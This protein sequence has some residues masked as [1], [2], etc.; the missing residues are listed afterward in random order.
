MKKILVFVF[1]CLFCIYNAECAVR[2][3]N[4]I[5]RG[6]SAQNTVS[7]K[8]VKTRNVRA[9]TTPNVTNR[10]SRKSTVETTP[11][12]QSVST[13]TAVN[14]RAS[15]ATRNST[16]K[17]Q[18]VVARATTADQVQSV[19]SETKTGLEY[20]QC[21]TAFFTCMDQFCQLKNDNYRRCSCSNRI[22]NFQEVSDGYKQASEKLTEFSE[23]LDVVGMSKEQATAMKTASEGEDALT[24]DK[25]A[26]KQLLQA[27]MNAIKGDDAKVG[28]KYQNLNSISL[29]EDF[30]NAFENADSGQ[31]IASYN[32]ATLY[33]AVFPR[34]KSVVKEDCNNASLQR[35]INAY[36]MAIEQDCNTVEAALKTQ[37]KKLK[38]STYQSSAM[39]DLARI[40]NRH[41][42]NEDDIATCMTNVEAAIQSE[43]V[44]GEKYHKC[45]D[46][47]QYIDITT[48][49][50]I[51]GVVDFYKLGSLLTFKTAETIENQHLSLISSNRQFVQFF[52]NKTKKF[53]KDALDKCSEQADTVW[54]QYLDRALVDI[55][56]MQQS[57]VKEI[58]QSCLDLVT[59]CYANQS[60]SIATAMANLTGDSSILI[61]PSVINLTTQMC[62][63]YI[64]SCNNMF[65]EETITAYINN[66]DSADAE[67]ACR[68]VVQQCFEKF[69]GTRY[70]N[71]Y[72]TQSGLFVP[73]SA[74]D[75]FTLYSYSTPQEFGNSN[76]HVV[77]DFIDKTNSNEFVIVS[78][79]AQ[80]LYNTEGCNSPEILER[81]FGGFNKYTYAGKTFYSYA[82]DMSYTVADATT[83]QEITYYFPETQP[84]SDDRITRSKGVATETYANIIDI[85]STQ[86]AGLKGKF[87]EYQNVS[88][89]GYNTTNSCKINTVDSTSAFFIGTDL[90]STLDYWYHFIPNE[91]MCP[92]HYAAKID[93][94]SWGI[95]SCWENGRY[96]SKNGTAQVCI[97]VL[98]IAQTSEDGTSDP[99]C[100][101]E[102]LG[103]T[104][105]SDL[106]SATH[107]WCQQSVSSS[108]G[109]ICPT[110][111]TAV[112]NSSVSCKF[113]TSWESSQTNPYQFGQ[114]NIQE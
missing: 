5:S 17:R 20:E 54:Q 102:L 95:C 41:N 25:S 113:G 106:A 2:G 108:N 57:K 91:N 14:P 66:K 87:L 96:R 58:K 9:Q 33:K 51:T 6:K 1:S 45:L 63:N 16:T 77:R 21:K 42:R 10:S 49:A 76:Q 89:Y 22:F 110:M 40:E 55:Y 46:Y 38:A 97:P 101:A 37:Q 59:A 60:T 8:T 104:L 32:G 47:G 64:D 24:E 78:P 81:V 103:E 11:R 31:I 27:I 43:E 7:T 13:R 65:G 74:I 29:S 68:A 111:V 82:N 100:T 39:L 98:P 99:V 12:I 34:C 109:V 75:W 83:N 86:C 62:S 94:D 72:Y 36:L 30:S 92:E 85:L 107:G 56:Y 88:R 93:T 67:I 3:E 28:G 44:C 69:G 23:N 52:E 70:E 90:E 61:N 26:S 105:P 80:E 114:W 15:V 50:P 4:T 73:G 84:K 48:G 18:N 79:C 35:A 19:A 71:F 53:A 112:Y